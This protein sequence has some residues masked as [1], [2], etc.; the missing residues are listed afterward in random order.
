M[1]RGDELEREYKFSD[2]DDESDDLGY[3]GGGSSFDEDDDEDGGWVL[4][5][6]DESLW[7]DADEGDD[8]DDDEAEATGGAGD[9][10][11][12]EEEEVFARPGRP[13]RPRRRQP[14]RP[15]AAAA[16]AAA[17]GSGPCT[18]CKASRETAAAKPAATKARA[19][20]Q[21]VGRKEG[22][23]ATERRKKAAKPAAQ[24]EGRQARQQRKAEAKGRREES[25]PRRK[26]R[27]ARQP[28]RKE[29]VASRQRST[30][31]DAPNRSTFD[32]GVLPARPAP[33]G[34][35]SRIAD[36]R[37]T[38]FTIS[39][40]GT[41]LSTELLERQL[42]DALPVTIYTARSR[43]PPDECPHRA[44]PVGEGVVAVAAAGDASARRSGSIA[45]HCLLASRS[46]TPCVAARWSRAVVRW[47]VAPATRIV[48]LAQMTPLHDE[49]HA[50][51]GFVV[52]HRRTS[53]RA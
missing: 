16:P 37:S 40:V 49:S 28:A 2:R 4:N 18:C 42:L 22:Q 27:L 29:E 43:R 39:I 51:T 6:R 24:Q 26:R 34:F 8:D 19:A 36:L 52:V 20:G 25:S 17:T 35:V 48:S 44:A 21:E 7:D 5:Q 10:E 13:G 53:R 41:M 1:P 9:E 47:E 30:A 31:H 23:Q 38:R 15:A 11:E 3:G 45:M 14:Q 32:R 33:R 12:E 50:V 46:S